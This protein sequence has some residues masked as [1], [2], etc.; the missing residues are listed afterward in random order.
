MYFEYKGWYAYLEEKGEDVK[1]YLYDNNGHFYKEK[2]IEP[3]TLY[4]SGLTDD[5]NASPTYE[6]AK[7]YAIVWIY[8]ITERRELWK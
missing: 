1:V 5:I 6:L 7:K 3:S 2:L 8:H 4:Y